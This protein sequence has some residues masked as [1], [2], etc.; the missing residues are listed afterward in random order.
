VII[1]IFGFLLGH[2]FQ[3][4]Q[5]FDQIVPDS[6]RP[7]LQSQEREV[8]VVEETKIEEESK[9]IRETI[10]EI[11]VSK[12]VISRQGS[13]LVTASFNPEEVFGIRLFEKKTCKCTSRNIF[14]IDEMPEIFN[15]AQIAQLEKN[16]QEFKK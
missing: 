3:T 15:S 9:T 1:F 2:L 8:Q 16:R 6:L 7:A 10:R 4:A 11:D 12:A 14:P 5:I 13:D